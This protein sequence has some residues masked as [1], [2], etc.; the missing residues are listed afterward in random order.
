MTRKRFRAVTGVAPTLLIALMALI[1]K[2]TVAHDPNEKEH[3]EKPAAH[4]HAT[5]P[6]DYAK[7]SAPTTLWTD[8][9]VLSRGRTIYETQCAVRHGPRGE[10]DGPAA[11]S[12]A[13]KPASFREPS[14]G[15]ASAQRAARTASTVL[16]LSTMTS[17]PRTETPPLSSVSTS[18]N[19]RATRSTARSSRTASANGKTTSCSLSM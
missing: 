8:A 3:V 19:A 11:S 16:S 2:T 15:A 18:S 7:Q 9:R 5:V 14:S 13:L 1:P 12:L 4:V 6:H 17:A 10:G